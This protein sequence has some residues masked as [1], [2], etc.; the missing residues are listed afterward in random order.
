MLQDLPS[1]G[2]AMEELKRI[3]RILE[4]IQMIAVFPRRY[5]RKD[6]A[7]RYE[8]S[9]RMVGKDIQVIRHGLRLP[10]RSSPEGYYFE[11]LP[12]LPAVQFPW[13]EGIALVMALQAAIHI[14]GASSPELR[15]AI[16]RLESLFPPDFAPLFQTLSHHRANTAQGKH[17]QDM[18]MLLNRALLEKRKVK[19]TYVTRSRSGAVTK[20]IVH[21]YHIMPYVRS[22]QLIAYCELREAVLMFK[23]DRIQEATLLDDHYRMPDDFDLDSYFGGAW[24]IIRGKGQSPEAIELLFQP[25]T[26]HRVMEEAW[27]PSQQAE[28]LPDGRVRFT[29]KATV[30]LEFIA[31]VLYYGPDVEVVRPMHL[32]QA[33]AAKHR[34]AMLIYQ[35]DEIHQEEAHD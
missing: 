27:H 11:S 14:P 1:G 5:R 15:A 26:G 13:T 21:P 3:S 8:I 33:I 30:T 34:Q 28:V 29:L 6:F 7:R 18:L 23:L 35:S 31:W 10:L 25:D 20:R 32:R 17:R 9:E 22:W 16:S 4:I 12:S 2:R 19:M 24:G